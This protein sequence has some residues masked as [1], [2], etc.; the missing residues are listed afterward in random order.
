MCLNSEVRKFAVAVQS[1]VSTKK[2]L[3]ICPVINVLLWLAVTGNKSH[4]RILVI[5]ESPI[6]RCV[7]S[8][9]VACRLWMLFVKFV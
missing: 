9:G 4:G 6:T 5:M 2:S 7:F 1:V 3:S 8:C